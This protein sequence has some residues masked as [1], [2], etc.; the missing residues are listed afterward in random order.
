MLYLNR[1]CFN[2][3]YRTN[4]AGQYNVPMGNDQ[5]RYLTKE[6]L[7]ACSALLQNTKLVAGDFT[8][9]LQ[10]V[11]AGDFVYLDPPFAV[12]SRRIF[13]EY[14]QRSFETSDMPRFAEALADIDRSKAH[15]LV[16]YADCREARD[17]ATD[18]NSIRLP[19]RRNIAGFGDA[20]RNAYEWLITNL[21]IQL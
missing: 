14:G 12:Q 18:W 17:I 4:L 15:F 11:S 20:R 8:R 19:I 5:G 10:E 21:P 3:I 7:L 16:S 13:R 9:T 1:N 2:G 6:E